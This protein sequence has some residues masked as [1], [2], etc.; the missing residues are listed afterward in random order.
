MDRDRLSALLE[1][2]RAEHRARNPRSA[3][4]FGGAAHLWT[5]VPMTWMANWAGPGAPI[6]PGRRPTG[7]RRS[8]SAP[9]GGGWDRVGQA[10]AR[11]SPRSCLSG[12][13][14]IRRLTAV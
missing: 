7:R 8:R 2:E 3:A 1:T 11:P 13:D 5:G 4:Q 6:V 14:W 12:S 10:P 9:G